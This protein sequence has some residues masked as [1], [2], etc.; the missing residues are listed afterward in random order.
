MLR[1]GRVALHTIS[2]CNH[3]GFVRGRTFVEA[4]DLPCGGVEFI[5]RQR[6]VLCE[7]QPD[8]VRMLRKLLWRIRADK[9]SRPCAGRQRV[10]S[11]WQFKRMACAETAAKRGRAPAELIDMRTAP[12]R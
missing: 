9:S 10:E 2:G 7:S 4:I 8:I 5:P 11:E 3:F 12:M 1:C 6:S